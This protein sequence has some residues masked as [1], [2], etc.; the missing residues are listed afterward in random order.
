MS[1]VE[2]YEQAAERARERRLDGVL[3]DPP[4]GIDPDTW[5]RLC[6]AID[7]S[8]WLTG[9]AHLGPRDIRDIARAA[10]AVLCPPIVPTTQDAP[11]D[12][13]SAGAVIP[14]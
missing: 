3:D 4:P 9:R 2:V 6:E 11:A 13:D 12:C 10:V 5:H 7:A 8:G 1:W 14:H